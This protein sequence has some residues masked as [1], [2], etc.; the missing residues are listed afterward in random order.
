MK[1][2]FEIDGGSWTVRAGLTPPA[3]RTIAYSALGRTVRYRLAFPACVY[4]V[5]T[6]KTLSTHLHVFWL[7]GDGHRLY[8]SRMCNTYHS[9]QVCM[10]FLP[11]D[12]LERVVANYWGSVF[13]P[14]EI[15]LCADLGE[16]NYPDSVGRN[17]IM[18]EYFADWQ[19]R[20]R[21]G[22]FRPR[23]IKAGITID[24]LGAPDYL[25]LIC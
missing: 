9:C 5:L 20:T 2:L 22:T 17:R 11:S 7:G 25:S 13:T 21:D 15:R 6:K 1:T 18:Q 10:N 19:R 4:S 16:D 8:K 24:D 23:F 14:S 12:S 3:T